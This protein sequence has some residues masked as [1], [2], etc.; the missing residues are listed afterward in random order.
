[1]HSHWLLWGGLAVCCAAGMAAVAH[2]RWLQSQTLKKCVLLSVGVHAVLAVVACFIG[3]AR[4]ASWG[5]ADEGRM[6]MEVVLLQESS[7]ETAT[8]GAETLGEE[9]TADGSTVAV[10]DANPTLEQP[11]PDLVPLLP[12]P[13]HADDAPAFADGAAQPPAPSSVDAVAQ[14]A[15][16][17]ASAVP[18]L[19]ADRVGGKRAAA[20]ATRGGSLETEQAVQAALAWLAAAQARDGHWSVVEHG[21]GVERA[22]QGHDRR[23]A[24]A[25]SDHGVTGLALLAFLGAGQ[26]HRD[27]PYADVVA[28]GLRFL[29]ERQRADGSLAGDA[30][31]FAALY[32]HGMATLALGEACALTQ[33]A[34]L[35]PAVERAVHYTL[36]MQHPTTGGWRYAAGDR[37]DTSQLGWQVMVLATARQAGISAGIEPAEARARTFLQSVSSGRAGGLAA[38]RPGERPSVAMTAEALLCRLF[39]GQ[40][41]EHAV[42]QEALESLAAAP[43]D[44]AHPNAYTW[45]YATLASFHAGG[46]QWEAWNTRLLAALLPLQR[47]GSDR[48]AGSWDPD[49]VW[50]GHG[51]RV[52]ATALSAMTLEVYYRHA[53]VHERQKASRERPQFASQTPGI[54]L[55]Q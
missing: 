42:V 48:L 50:G 2:A 47:Q 28:R 11:P 31:F 26:T 1:M 22:V 9:A 34:T 6:T 3:G 24:G 40:P 15:D 8:G 52:Y 54:R 19:Y 53:P 51:G 21:G 49:P 44:P 23:G 46:P 4:P 17:A 38:Y 30:E 43:P 36:A 55:E 33:D 29:A 37:G 20:A 16:A 25:K 13:A 14:Q 5:E 45:Y 10:T 27:G 12:A 41:V 18:T 32:C 7:D 35:R 39:L